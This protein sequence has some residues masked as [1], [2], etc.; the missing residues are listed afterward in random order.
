MIYKIYFIFW[1]I[2]DVAVPIQ[3]FNKEC[4]AFSILGA[5]VALKNNKEE[6]EKLVK[7][8]LFVAT[9]AAIGY[10]GN[11]IVHLIKPTSESY[12]VW[13]ACFL[14]AFFGVKFLN[15]FGDGVFEYLGLI[16]KN[17]KEDDATGS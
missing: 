16:V 6:Q 17:K 12:T 10:M 8:V 9:N 7:A 15:R 2:L 4:L 11:F 1:V 5:L 3:A 13:L 14:I